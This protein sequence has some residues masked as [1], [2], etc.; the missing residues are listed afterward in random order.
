[1]KKAETKQNTSWKK[2]EGRRRNSQYR[3]TGIFEHTSNKTK[4]NKVKHFFL[5]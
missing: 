1:M 4:K 5:N 2:T 3:D